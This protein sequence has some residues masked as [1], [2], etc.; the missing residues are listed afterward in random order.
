MKAFD[1]RNRTALRKTIEPFD[2]LDLYF[3]DRFGAFATKGQIEVCKGKLARTTRTVHNGEDI[4]KV[5][6]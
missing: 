2:V 5:F 1:Y 4:S 6:L 3:T